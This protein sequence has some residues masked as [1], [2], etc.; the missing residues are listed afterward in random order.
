MNKY[1]VLGIETSGILCSI[2]WWQNHQTLLEY[3]IERKNAHATILAELIDDGF[4]ELNLNKVW[5]EIYEFDEKKKALY[6]KI[7]LKQ[8]GLLRQNY[9][10]EGKWWDSIILSLLKEEIF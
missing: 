1:F 4:K 5:T 6:D 3:N 10:Y 9:W 2:A 7:G 8:D